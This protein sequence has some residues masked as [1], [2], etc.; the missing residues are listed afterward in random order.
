MN[1]LQQKA[2][3]RELLVKEIAALFAKEN[4]TEEDET[5][6]E[7]KNAA[8]KSLDVEITRLKEIADIAAVNAARAVELSAVDNGNRPDGLG[9]SAPS[10]S[11]G[12]KSLELP[13]RFKGANPRHFRSIAGTGQEAREKA[14]RFG[15]Y[16]LATLGGNQKSAAWCKDHGLTIIKAQ[17]ENVN[18]AGGFLV[19]EELD[20]DLIQLREKFGVVRQEFKRVTMKSDTKRRPRRVG[21]LKA[22]FLSDGDGI[23]Q[24]QKGWDSVNL[25]AE[26]IAI[27]ALFGSE[28]SEDA[29]IDVA[30]DLAYEIG[31]AFS[32]T[33]DEA[34]LLGDGTSTYGGFVGVT[35]KLQQMWGVNGGAGLIQ[36]SGAGYANSWGGI[37]LSDLNRVKAAVPQYAALTDPCWMCSRAFYA[38]VMERLLTAAGGNRIQDIQNGG[39]G[40]KFLGDRVVIAQVMPMASATQQIPLLYGSF[41]L[42]ADFGDRRETT[43]AISNEYAFGNDQ[44]AI[45]G[46][47]RFSINVHD[48]GTVGNGGNPAQP[49][50]QAGAI[51]G[52]ITPNA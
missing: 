23:T 27:L 18:D 52:L 4:V 45:R 19:P 36:A 7:Q 22:Y 12:I 21:G 30:D 48:V 2:A 47:E 39:D 50:P 10:A 17:S 13:A 15:Q 42:G 5:L 31:W 33:E 29:I 37:L 14:Y 46:T 25:T 41:R 24:S 16:L 9:A 20:G 34:G 1:K 8:V 28:L 6:I 32:L 49:G 51:V 43:I 40:E 3:E 11:T 26:K 38:G 44:V 35:T